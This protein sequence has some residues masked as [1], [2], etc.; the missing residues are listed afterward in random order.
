MERKIKRT[1]IIAVSV[2][3]VL[4]VVLTALSFVWIMYLTSDSYVKDSFAKN[5]K[6]FNCVSEYFV[7][8]SK[9]YPDNTTFMIGR[10]YNVG[11]Y[12]FDYVI[13][14]MESWEEVLWKTSD[15]PNEEEKKALNK[16][17]RL[18]RAGSLSMRKRNN[19]CVIEFSFNNNS[20]NWKEI[21]YSTDPKQNISDSL[22][23]SMSESYRYSNIELAENWTFWYTTQ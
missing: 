20:D 5:F 16:V 23:D 10:V 18:C 13:R 17:F 6:S 4:S 2:C 9:N 14:R 11:H 7:K 1:K 22:R 19:A 15:F 21:V 8:V 3:A 12:E